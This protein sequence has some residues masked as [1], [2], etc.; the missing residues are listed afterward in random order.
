MKLAKPK[1]HKHELE[2]INWY[3][4]RSHYHE[5]R[6]RTTVDDRHSHL[7]EGVT[8]AT[9][10]GID[11]HVHYYEGTTSFV[12]GHVHRFQGMTGPAVALPDGSHVHVFGGET[13]FEDGHRHYYQGRTGRGIPAM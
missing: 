9:Q 6:T 4:G 10:G 13:T 11:N 1:E 3:G 5:Y 2:L 7:V 12:D 8:S